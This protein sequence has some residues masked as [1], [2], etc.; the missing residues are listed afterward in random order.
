M[1]GGVSSP[2]RAFRAVGGRP[3]FLV[4]GRGARVQD[5][6]GRW[7]VDY[8]CAWGP[9]ILGH[10]R[11]EVVRT[12]VM[13]ARR[14]FGFG[15]TH[16]EE[17]RLA[18]LVRDA[19]PSMERVRFVGSGTE[20]AM[21]AV[22]LARAAT[23]RE[24]LVKFEGCYHGHAD[25]LLARA[26]SGPATF[27]LPDSP[28]VLSRVAERTIV[29]PYNDAEAAKTC[30]LRHGERIAAVIVEP[31]AGNMGVIP[32]VD[33]FLRTLRDVTRH[34]GTLLIFDEVITG[35]RLAWGG[36]QA[37][38][39]IAPDLTI[40]GKILGGG[41][42]AAAYG[43]RADLMERLA[44]AGP[45]YQAGTL[46]GHPLAMAAGAAT[47]SILRRERPYARLAAATRDLADGLEAAARARGVPLAVERIGSLWTPFFRER[48]ILSFAAAAATDRKAY[49]R[50]FHG[51]RARGIALPPSALETAFVSTAHG[52]REIDAT[53]AAARAALKRL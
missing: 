7:Y 35:F 33:G 6:Q 38:Y 29:L 26:G 4:A 37:L 14:G 3:L 25:G 46:A 9:A 52:P 45:V 18:A 42:P 20:A 17:V 21:S 11:R 31:V 36:A 13:A 47:L 39:G 51:M 41:L 28:G 27:G 10:A 23:R 32:P 8:V 15:A 53:I 12:V 19:F 2:V 34:Y 24:I 50:F 48:P 1:P 22:R 44:P 16:P 43:G 40:L 5:A 30:F 49:A